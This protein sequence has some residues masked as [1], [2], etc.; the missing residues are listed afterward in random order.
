[1]SD[2]NVTAKTFSASLAW[3]PLQKQV[4]ALK[5]IPV[6]H[7]DFDYAFGLLAEILVQAM[8]EEADSS[9][10]RALTGELMGVLVNLG[11]ADC[12]I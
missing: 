6:E 8:E 2:P 7:I 5:G 11:D 4:A 9:P 12:T 3:Q 1:M 10:A